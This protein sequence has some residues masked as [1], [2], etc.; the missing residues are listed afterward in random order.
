MA[1]LAEQV[2]KKIRE[3]ITHE[4]WLAHLVTIERFGADGTEATFFCPFHDNHNTACL[5]FNLETGLW[6][7]KNSDCG[8]KGDPIEFYRRLKGLDSARKAIH[9]LAKELDLLREITESEVARYHENLMGDPSLL[10]RACE[11]FGVSPA[12]LKQFQIGV[13]RHDKWLSSRFVIP[14][15]TAEGE[16][17]D[18]RSYNNKLTPKIIHWAVGHG[19]PRFFPV[20][21]LTHDTV[22][23]F[24]GEKDCLRAWD[25]GITNALT[26][27]A[28]VGIL[29]T[30]AAVRL[31]GKTVYLC[32]D[33]DAAGTEG[34][35]KVAARLA[36]HTKALYLIHLPITGLPQNGDFS[37]WVNR[38]NG[39]TEWETLVAEAERVDPGFKFMEEALEEEPV[40]VRFDEV[41]N[42]SFYKTPVRFLAHS[43][44][45][46]I[47]LDGFQI[48]T[49]V[50]LDC[51]RNQGKLCKGCALENLDPDLRPWEFG[52]N[53]RAESALQ[54]FRTNGLG[55]INAVRGMFGVKSKCEVVQVG[56]IER[57]VVQHLFLSPP[58][59]LAVSREFENEGTITAFY[60]GPPINDNRDYWF[61]GY[62]Q[63]DPKNQKS[64]LN[65]H[66]A[67]P[68]KNA[69]DHFV[70]NDAVYQALDWFRV[71]N[72]FTV[73]DHL[74]Q[75]YRY[76]EEDIGIWGQPNLLQV[77]F[78]ATF[79][80]RS[81]FCK[82]KQVENGCVEIGII[83]DTGV[84]KSTCTRRWL[85]FVNVGEFIS[86]ENVSAAG[87][88][89]G[90]EFIDKIPVV[91]WGVLPRNHKGLVA[92]DEVDEMQKRNKDITA[93]LTALRSSGMAEITKIHSART[94]AQVRMIWIT[95]PVEG[96]E[97]K[98]FDC[99][100]RAIEGV[101]AN[102]QD[103]ARFTKFLA[104]SRDSVSIETITQD[105]PR[106]KKPMIREHF[107]NLAILAW[108]LLSDQV[109]F[110]N[111][112]FI[113]VERETKQLVE[114]YDEAIPLVEK[115]RAFD[116]LAKL[117]V[118][119]AVLCGAFTEREGRLILQVDTHHV[120]FA[121]QHLQ[122]IYD[123]P[124]M[125]YD[126][127]SHKEKGRSILVNPEGVERSLRLAAKGKIKEMV[128]YLLAMQ[129]LTRNHLDEFIGERL[130]A[131][132]LWATLLSSNCLVY[133]ANGL[134]VTKTRPFVELLEAMARSAE[135]VEEK[136]EIRF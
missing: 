19:A 17:P 111:D 48:P 112:A 8:A 35:Q 107:N 59:D 18:L 39:L 52:V 68:A 98:S 78:D 108:S 73:G 22:V 66:K 90:I 55:Q 69:I 121:L 77:L 114:K 87:L 125:G 50:A 70:V 65:L 12:T 15:R 135:K 4:K 133:T 91:K 103:V 33:I 10:Q 89:G 131:S 32:F 105:R 6:E 106:I 14:I 38:G 79:S 95:N 117:S 99:G 36:P 86:A 16:I 84:A 63:A 62:V 82:H 118:P 20:T 130:E 34:A 47:G 25:L 27:T 3:E 64:V 43:T 51:P 7:C 44:G 134:S 72:G 127:F 119:I 126:R 110:T 23:L 74:A 76:V 45:K 97:I 115:G 11:Q 60:N 13:A 122:Q 58:V 28:G 94:P 136:Q 100:C 40:T 88:I 116:K 56:T 24:E 75:L 31:K 129:S 85:D 123:D 102:R 120:S 2:K 96:R 21:A 93:Q 80:V 37:D 101:I 83:G 1:N 46:S 53:P 54:L 104:I 9:Q 92:L 57:G 81:F 30:D 29:P 41:T 5:C 61:E 113:L 26:V 71:K 42:Q 67:E 128:G 109:E 124:V 132:S 49:K